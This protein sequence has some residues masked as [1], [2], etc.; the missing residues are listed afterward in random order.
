MIESIRQEQCDGD[1]SVQARSAFNI[2]NIFMGYYSRL[3]KIKLKRRQNY[4]KYK[5]S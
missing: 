4:I 1:P 3:L 5:I 2:Q